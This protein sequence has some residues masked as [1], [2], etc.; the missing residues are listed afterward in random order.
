MSKIDCSITKNYLSEKAR[1][2]HNCNIMCE[3]CE[4]SH[5]R[6]D[7]DLDCN[8]LERKYPEI[9]IAI[10]QSGSDYSPILTIQDD[11]FEKNPN[12]K[13]QLGTQIPCVCPKI[14]GYKTNC[15]DYYT[16][17]D[18]K[19]YTYDYSWNTPL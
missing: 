12:A 17:C 6:N 1:L 14:L 8:E 2:T 5:W 4:L 16:G 7:M 19:G 10:V 3:D 11:F 9:A 13:R 15:P 18:R